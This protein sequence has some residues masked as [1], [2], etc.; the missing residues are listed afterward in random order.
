MADELTNNLEKLDSKDA[1]AK[2]ESSP[3]STLSSGQN[4]EIFL[5]KSTTNTESLPSLSLEDRANTTGTNPSGAEK[6]P[7]A[8]TGAGGDAAKTAGDNSQQVP[9]KADSTL[10]GTSSELPLK[11]P[12]VQPDRAAIDSLPPSAGDNSRTNNA[13]AATRATMRNFLD[14][15]KRKN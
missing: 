9:R 8:G 2:I 4:K 13:D 11:V 6:V 3:L 14:A 1:P 5:G 12:P 10:Q 15:A 7:L